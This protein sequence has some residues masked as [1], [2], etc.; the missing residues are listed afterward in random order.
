MATRF[1]KGMMVTTL[2]SM[3]MRYSGYGGYPVFNIPKGAVGKII[4]ANVPAVTGKE[5]VFQAVRFS[6]F[7]YQLPARYRSAVIE[8]DVQGDY[9]NNELKKANVR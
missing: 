8:I 9:W 4:H 3:P 2:K 5:R 6:P 7:L 1:K